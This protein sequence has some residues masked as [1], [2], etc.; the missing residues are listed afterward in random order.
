M[1][2]IRVRFARTETDLQRKR[3]EQS[4]QVFEIAFFKK[5]NPLFKYR[6]MLYDQ[7]EWVEMGVKNEVIN[8][9]KTGNKI[10]NIQTAPNIYK[11]QVSKA[12]QNGTASL[13]KRQPKLPLI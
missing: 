13:L 9:T 11:S 8:L 12:K 3:R 5:I 10:G 7:D 2:P 4:Y 6:Q 1:N